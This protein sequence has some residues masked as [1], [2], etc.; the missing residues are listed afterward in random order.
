ML[1]GDLFVVGL[2]AGLGWA[3]T[4]GLR[5]IVFM[6]GIAVLTWI[7]LTVGGL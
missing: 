7:L 5:P 3:L 1:I 6:L 2:M 4:R